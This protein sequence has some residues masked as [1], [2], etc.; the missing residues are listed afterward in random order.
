MRADAT[1]PAR[2]YHLTL[3]SNL[4]SIE[5][6][7]LLSATA[8]RAHPDVGALRTTDPGPSLAY[9][10]AREMLAPGVTLNDQAPMPPAALARCLV[11]IAPSEWYALLDGRVFFWLDPDRVIRFRRAARTTAQVLLVVDVATLLARYG[12]RAALT[13]INTGSA[14]RRPAP[15]GRATFVAV[16]AWRTSAWASEADGLGTRRRAPSH[17]PAELTIEGGVPDVQDC[18]I[19][20][21]SLDPGEGDIRIAALLAG[22]AGAARMGPGKRTTP[23]APATTTDMVKVLARSPDR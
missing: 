17:P 8:L 15:R 1:L 13:P 11:G 20:R 22:D 5:R 19:G 23:A 14:R 16:D 12:G 6:R 3:A 2:A 9:R 18:I 4:A 10:A 21:Y 7:G